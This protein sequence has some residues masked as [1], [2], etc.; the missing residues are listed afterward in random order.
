[1]SEGCFLTADKVAETA[2]FINSHQLIM[3]KS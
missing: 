2:S 3:L 1:M